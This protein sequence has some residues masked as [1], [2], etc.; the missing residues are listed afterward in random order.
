MFVEKLASLDDAFFRRIFELGPEHQPHGVA[1]RHHAPDAR[2]GRS[3]QVR[4]LET[5]AV[6]DDDRAVA[7]GDKR[8]P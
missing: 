3:W 4:G 2:G 5:A 7:L 6:A 1:N 8:H